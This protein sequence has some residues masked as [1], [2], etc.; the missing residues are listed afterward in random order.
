VTSARCIGAFVAVA[1]GAMTAAAMPAAAQQ[2]DT[3]APAP[4]ASAERVRRGLEQPRH[5]ALGDS[6]IALAPDMPPHRLGALTFEP[7]DAAGQV[8]AVRVPVGDLLSRSARSI[9]AARHRR[10]ER[11]ARDQV[12]KALAQP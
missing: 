11:A 8:I 5:L 4:I 7:P 10:A 12:R 3:A 9:A 1:V 2:S 6:L